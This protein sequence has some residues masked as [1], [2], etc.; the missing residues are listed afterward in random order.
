[1]TSLAIATNY[2]DVS[3]VEKVVMSQSAYENRR[4]TVRSFKKAMKLGRFAESQTTDIET[5]K[6]KDWHAESLLVYCFLI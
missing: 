5:D 6:V 4:D 1:M 2:T 3:Q